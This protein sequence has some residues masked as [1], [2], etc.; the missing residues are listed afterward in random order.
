[1]L[2]FGEVPQPLCGLGGGHPQWG[3]RD[4]PLGFEG[5]VEA[6]SPVSVQPRSQGVGRILNTQRYPCGPGT[7]PRGSHTRLLM[8]TAEPLLKGKVQIG[9]E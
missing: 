5:Q 2:R 7:P 9:K 3:G 8:L 1:M 4:A 6:G